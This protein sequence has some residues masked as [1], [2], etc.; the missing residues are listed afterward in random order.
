MH[1]KKRNDLIS[2]CIRTVRAV[3]VKRKETNQWSAYDCSINRSMLDRKMPRQWGSLLSTP[4]CKN[5]VMYT[6]SSNL[7]FA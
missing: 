4:G 5:A 2:H 3:G 1:R 6:L 7:S